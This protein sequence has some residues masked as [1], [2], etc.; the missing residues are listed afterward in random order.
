L[1]AFDGQSNHFGISTTLITSIAHLSL[2]LDAQEFISPYDTT[3]SVDIFHLLS[4]IPSTSDMNLFVTPTSNCSDHGHA[5]KHAIF[6][7][8]EYGCYYPTPW[9]KMRIKSSR[10]KRLLMLKKEMDTNAWRRSNCDGGVL[11]WR[12]GEKS[13]IKDMLNTTNQRDSNVY[14]RRDKYRSLCFL[15][16]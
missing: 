8:G 7:R 3:T 5:D 11:R 1:S 14:W 10:K 15:D 16:G 12:D 13:M 6:S 2:S 9:L 4:T